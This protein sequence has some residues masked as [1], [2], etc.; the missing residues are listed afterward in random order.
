LRDSASAEAISIK[1]SYA[2]DRN[3]LISTGARNDVPD[4]LDNSYIT[5]QIGALKTRIWDEYTAIPGATNT[6]GTTDIITKNLPDQTSA[7]TTRLNSSYYYISDFASLTRS[8]PATVKMF[9]K[10]AGASSYSPQLSPTYTAYNTTH[11]NAIITTT[12]KPK[13]DKLCDYY[14]ADKVLETEKENYQTAQSNFN[15][16]SSDA[17][18]AS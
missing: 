5:S 10:I 15:T 1:S 11:L 8:Y 3:R 16:Y 6:L 9:I 14:F 18:T 4:N 17:A 13:L 7:P 2:S 12:V